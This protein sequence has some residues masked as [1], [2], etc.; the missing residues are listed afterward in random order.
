MKG[1]CR[2]SLGRF[3]W[4]HMNLHG[5]RVTIMGLGHFGGG[6]AAARWLARHGAQ[7]TVTD[8][9]DEHTLAASLALLADVPIAEY[10]LGGH[11]RDDF[12]RAELI[13]VNPAVPPESPMLQVA[14]QNGV[15][16]SSEIE[17]FI[18]ACP[19][20]IIAVT[21]SNGKSTTAAMV[22]AV[23]KAEGRNTYLGGNIGG[24]LLEHLDDI[25]PDDTVVLEISSFQL[26]HL[27]EEAPGP[28]IAVVTGCSPNHLDWHG[29]YE[30][31]VAAKQR[32][33]GGQSAGDVAVLNVYDPEVAR[34][35]HL[36]AGR[37]APLIAP[38]RIPPL[39]VPG[40]HNR[41]NAVCAAT[42]A[43]AAGCG[44]QAI[45]RGLE[46]FEGL[47]QRL[48]PVGV[49][50]GRRFYN[51]S[52][53]T[54]PESTAAALKSISEPVWLLAGGSDKG[55]DFEHLATAIAE[56]A[57]GV[58]LFGP[59]RRVLQDLIRV[60]TAGVDCATLETMA[61]ALHWCWE[62]SRP[63]EPI[64]LSPACPSGGQF[65]NFRQR[66]EEFVEL[67]KMLGSEINQQIH[68]IKTDDC[69]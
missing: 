17:L 43:L 18:G 42:A 27:S 49:V 29:C 53:A 24:S 21:G 48:Q 13:V 7:L 58:A 46:T 68:Q 63:G 19:A 54:T 15:P 9:D 52:A 62:H 61:E 56:N 3:Y 65:R 66:G 11:C 10:R 57:K 64:L 33:L 22:A 31:Y 2:G 60:R 4:V 67:V 1:T 40:K 47:P 34:W 16:L 8:L 5:R 26:H 12:R 39:G 41:I 35:G 32:I 37:C 55:C 50:G 36:A 59:I 6:V 69:Y 30:D 20:Q 28:Q 23:L 25:R 44:W 38:G 45:G 51:D 14:K